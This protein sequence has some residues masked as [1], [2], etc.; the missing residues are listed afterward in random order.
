MPIAVNAGREPELTVIGASIGGH[1]FPVKPKHPFYVGAVRIQP[2]I[3][4][5]IF[6]LEDII[7]PDNANCLVGLRDIVP[8][9]EGIVLVDLVFPSS[10]FIR[11]KNSSCFFPRPVQQ[12]GRGSLPSS[13]RDTARLP[14]GTTR[15][16]CHPLYYFDSRFTNAF[17]E[18]ANNIIKD[19]EKQGK[20]YSFDTLRDNETITKDNFFIIN[21]QSPPRHVTS[22]V[23]THLMILYHSS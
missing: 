15:D 9:D 22:C 2:A 21:Q 16:M 20:G 1:L 5:D 12:Q 18:S 4:G 23:T 14:L 17:S 8:L 13:V 19:I 10:I 11:H 3:R 6:Y 7:C